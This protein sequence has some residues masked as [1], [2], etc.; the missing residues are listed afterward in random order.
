MAVEKRR[1]VGQ[2]PLDFDI[3]VGLN[4]LSNPL[5]VH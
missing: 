1:L 5:T 4:G 2:K 3:E